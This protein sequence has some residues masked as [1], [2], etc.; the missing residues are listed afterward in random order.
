MTS[1]PPSATSRSSLAIAAMVAILPG[2]GTGA[3]VV[4]HAVSLIFLAALAWVA[5]IIYREHRSSLYLLPAT[6]GAR[7]CTAPSRCWR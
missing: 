1:A 7:C 2:G 5:A 3:N 6:A 4:L